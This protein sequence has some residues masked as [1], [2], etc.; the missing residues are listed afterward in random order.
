MA[1]RIWPVALIAALSMIKSMLPAHAAGF[2]VEAL[3]EVA[4]RDPSRVLRQLD[5]ARDS[6]SSR[7]RYEAGVEGLVDVV[8]NAPPTSAKTALA[9]QI[10]GALSQPWET[11]RPELVAERLNLLT[12]RGKIDARND[13]SRALANRAGLY[14]DATRQNIDDPAGYRAALQGYAGMSRYTQTPYAMV[15]QIRRD[16]LLASCLHNRACDAD[17]AS[18]AADKASEQG[19]PPDHAALT[20]L[21]SLSPTDPSSNHFRISP[22]HWRWRNDAAFALG[23]AHFLAGDLEQAREVFAKVRDWPPLLTTFTDDLTEADASRIKRDEPDYRDQIFIW[24]A[25]PGRSAVHNQHFSS[26]TVGSQ[27]LAAL[28]SAKGAESASAGVAAF[29]DVFNKIENAD[30]SIIFGS[31]RSQKQARNFLDQYQSTLDN[32]SRGYNGILP[33]LTLEVGAPKGNSNWHSVRTR[34]SLTDTQVRDVLKNLRETEAFRK[35]QPY[36]DRPRVQ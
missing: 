23:L 21:R 17:T 12:A 8:I 6:A 16:L 5:E 11:N 34:G 32:S 22:S 31:F 9:A 33:D 20:L 19:Q 1:R 25:I 3:L 4:A 15:S 30:N 7:H 14:I 36:T 26:Q 28:E 2:D 29:I 18:K 10:L 24:A 35:V 13:F 27:A